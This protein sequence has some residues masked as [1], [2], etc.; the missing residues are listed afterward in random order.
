MS[1]PPSVKSSCRDWRDDLKEKVRDMRAIA[2]TM[3]EAP[4]RKVR[5]KP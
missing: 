2:L 4:D 3:I 5:W 1:R